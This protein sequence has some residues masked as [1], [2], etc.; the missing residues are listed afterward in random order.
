MKHGIKIHREDMPVNRTTVHRNLCGQCVCD[1]RRI[2]T[3]VEDSSSRIS[4]R[5][6]HLEDDLEQRRE[7]FDT[8][9]EGIALVAAEWHQIS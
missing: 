4:A 5:G 7:I 8:A 6:G 1:G 3:S 2:Y 9:G